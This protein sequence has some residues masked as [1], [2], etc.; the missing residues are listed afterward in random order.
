M[1]IFLRKGTYYWVRDGRYMG[2]DWS[3]R[4]S[5]STYGMSNQEVYGVIN[6]GNFKLTLE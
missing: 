5:S 6:I 4:T 1:I 2:A 3:S